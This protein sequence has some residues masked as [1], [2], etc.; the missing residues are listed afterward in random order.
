MIIADM[1]SLLGFVAS[2]AS[3]SLKYQQQQQPF[4]HVDESVPHTQIQLDSLS[5]SKQDRPLSGRFLHITDFHPDRYYKA[6]SSSSPDDGTCHHGK[7]DAGYYGQEGSDC[8]APLVLIDE[9]FRWIGENIKDDIDFVIWTGD[10]VR[11]DNDEAIPRDQN[12]IIE[13]NRY[14]SQKWVDLFA[15]RDHSA[16]SVAHPSIPVIPTFG[17][18][19]ILPHNIFRSGPNTW[20]KKFAEIWSPFI[21]EDQRH[22]FV[23]GG[24]LTSEVIPGKLAVISLNTMYFFDSNSAVDGCK[25]KSEPGYEHMEWLRVQL[26]ILRD[27]GMKAILMGH[28]APARSEEKTNWDE[29]CWQKYT[30]WMDRYRDVV[31]VA[32]QK[33]QASHF[34]EIRWREIYLPASARLCLAAVTVHRKTGRPHAGLDPYSVVNDTVNQMKDKSNKR[35]YRPSILTACVRMRAQGQR[36]RRER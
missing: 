12:E 27:R 21:P 29:T 1:L 7:G 20:T 15:T 11:H 13:L 19:D 2:A 10:S 24:W 14:M 8:D 9:T 4:A 22:S 25:D 3:L 31:V 23:E 6:G 34:Q 30:L 18:N 5:G 26:Q 36:G 17:N 28:V 33:L 32:Q 35:T 16:Q